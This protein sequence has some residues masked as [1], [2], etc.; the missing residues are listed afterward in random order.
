[1]N[2]EFSLSISVR[3]VVPQQEGIRLRP[4]RLRPPQLLLLAQ[5][6]QAARQPVCAAKKLRKEERRQEFEEEEAE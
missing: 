3:L 4:P 2:P 1:M 5:G 6:P